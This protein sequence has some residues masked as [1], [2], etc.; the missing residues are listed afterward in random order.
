MNRCKKL[1]GISSLWGQKLITILFDVNL[2][3]FKV[4]YIASV[5]GRQECMKGIPF[6][7]YMT[8]HQWVIGSRGNL[9]SSRTCLSL[10]MRILCCLNEMLWSDTYSCSVK[11]HKNG[12]LS[13]AAAENLKTPRVFN[14][15]CGVEI[16]STPVWSWHFNSSVGYP[17]SSL[18]IVPN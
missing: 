4:I 7:Q 8:L 17:A 1:T 10:H 12:I 16:S 5:L 13:C 3:F 6:F 9:H 18:I 14:V 15:Y 11:F 2:K